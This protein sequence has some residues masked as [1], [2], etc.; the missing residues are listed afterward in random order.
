MT[1]SDLCTV[2][3]PGT[4]STSA[5]K[6]IKLEVPGL[7]PGWLADSVSANILAG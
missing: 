4:L 2:V 7:V 3:L 1:L 6:Q 5:E